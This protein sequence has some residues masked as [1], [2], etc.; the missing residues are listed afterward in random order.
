[1]YDNKEHLRYRREFMNE[2][3]RYKYPAY[4]KLG[5]KCANCNMNDYRCL[6][7]D[8]INGNGSLQGNKKSGNHLWRLITLHDYP[9]DNLQLLCANCHMIKTF[10]N[11]DRYKY[12]KNGVYL[13]KVS[14]CL[15][16]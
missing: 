16:T 15:T 3:L 7:I 1:M 5:G 14:Q 13:E 6:Q 11:R 12:R 8:H 2:N 9:L 4:D 10:E